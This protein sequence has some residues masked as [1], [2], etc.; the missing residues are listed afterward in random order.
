MNWFFIALISALLS[1]AAAIA[2]KKA[3]FKMDAAEFSFILAVFNFVLSIPFF[4]SLNIS[5]LSSA[6]VTVLFV[7]SVIGVLAFLCVML[8]I[9]NLEISGALPLMALTPAFVALFAF[10]FLGEVIT[11]LEMAGMSLL[12]IGT[13]ILDVDKEQKFFIPFRI[14]FKSKYYHYIFFALLLFT[15]SSILDKAL[16]VR[17]KISP[18]AIVGI[19]HLFFF[20]IFL[21]IFVLK[22]KKPLQYLKSIDSKMY[23]WI[24][25]ISVI[26]IGYRYT[27]IL[28]IKTAPV[29]LVLSV[30]RIS[31]FIAAV[32]GGKIFKEKRLFVKAVAAAIMI[33]G[34]VLIFRD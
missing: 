1:A 3:L 23:M 15:A 29:A 9:K 6:G 16:L 33:A 18:F 5:E 11:G 19:Q 32:A 28:A 24:V 17:M 2:Q 22:N 8:A 27:Q 20:I 31:V 10:I 12:L 30:K 4:F 13:Y 25:M 26:T 34:A 14:L 21:A 7:K